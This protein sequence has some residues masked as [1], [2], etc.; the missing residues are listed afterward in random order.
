WVNLPGFSSS[1]DNIQIQRGVG[2]SA[3][4]AG[5]FGATI[6]FNTNEINEGR[7]LSLDG[8]IGSFGTRR[9]E[10]NYT[11]GLLDNGLKI[12]ARYSQIHSDGFVE[13]ASADLEG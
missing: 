4:G 8:S 1:A 2:T 6:D 5:A 11:S 10:I 3:N 7:R 12:D 9:G 13:R